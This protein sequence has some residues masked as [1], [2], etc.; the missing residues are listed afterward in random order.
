MP[1]TATA[2]YIDEVAARIGDLMPGKDIG[3]LRLY[4]LLALTAG[5]RTTLENVHDAWAVWRAATR[6]DHPDLVPFAELAPHVQEH[7]R[8][9][10]EAVR[11]V[12]AARAGKDS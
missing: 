6:P 2:N 7:D 5:T 4:A 3:L 8:K 9:H 1:G 10:A 11:A 12:A